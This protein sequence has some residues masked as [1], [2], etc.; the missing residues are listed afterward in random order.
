MTQSHS[1][2]GPRSS[3][4]KQKVIVMKDRVRDKVYDCDP[5][6]VKMLDTTTSFLE[7]M[8]N[9]KKIDLG[10]YNS[11]RHQLTTLATKFSQ[12]CSCIKKKSN[13]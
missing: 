8:F 12:D 4:E 7:D 9:S 3:A 6:S 10:D 13:F 2:Q 11:L 5:I 1:G